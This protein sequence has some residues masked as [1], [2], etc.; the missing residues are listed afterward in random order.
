MP[1]IPKL[2]FCFPYRGVGGVPLLF[3][4]IAEEL[5]ARSKAETYL[6]D[7]SDGFMAK[8]RKEGLSHFIEY[9]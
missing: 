1:D 8:H 6:V 7:Y 9:R 4:R 5:S 3:L 2:F